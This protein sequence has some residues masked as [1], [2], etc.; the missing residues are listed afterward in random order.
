MFIRSVKYSNN[1]LGWVIPKINLHRKNLF[2][3]ASAAGKTVLLNTIF[4]IA[5][6]AASGIQGVSE[7]QQV[8]L[9]NNQP[10]AGEWVIE[11][12]LN[13][14]MFSW[15]YGAEIDE[16]GLYMITHD[17][18][19]KRPPNTESDVTIYNR[20]KDGIKLEGQQLP[21]IFANQPG[22]FLFK[23]HNDIINISNFFGGFLRRS[24]SGGD[25][26]RAAAVIADI[27][28]G[29][30]NKTDKTSSF[31]DIARSP[32]LNKKLYLVYKD[33]PNKFEN[34]VS[35]FSEIFPSVKSL[36]ITDAGMKLK[37]SIKKTII[38]LPIVVI[39]EEGIAQDLS[40]NQLSSGMLK[41]LLMLTDIFT[42]N[43]GGVYFIDEYENSLGVNVIGFFPEI[44]DDVGL[45]KQF[46]LTSHNP[47]VINKF[48][49]N[50]WFLIK[51]KG[52]KIRIT[53]GS[54]LESR[55]SQSKQDYFIQLIN[56]I[57]DDI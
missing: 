31:S 40:L 23:N 25:L 42:M 52:S 49:I 43:E 45:D 3:G 34:I 22:L 37:P 20:D 21:N 10:L 50:D 7:L 12:E 28:F 51:R 18:L 48:S 38:D 46:I 36:E 14:T 47:Y 35:H 32:S 13:G 1:K 30:K 24:F 17:S 27:T 4:G 33:Y 11:L 39:K 57:N 29:T 41:V 19:I 55:Y 5:R 6:T 2:V 44:M 9:A 15:D 54:D 8:N 53:E 56:D 26:E 16:S